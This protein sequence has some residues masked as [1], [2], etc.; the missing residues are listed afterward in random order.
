MKWSDAA[1]ATR[2]RWWPACHAGHGRPSIWPCRPWL[3]MSPISPEVPDGGQHENKQ[4]LLRIH[5]GNQKVEGMLGRKWFLVVF[6]RLFCASQ[7]KDP[8]WGADFA[9]LCQRVRLTVLKKRWLQ[10]DTHW[11]SEFRV[12]H[13]WW[14]SGI[15]TRFHVAGWNQFWP[16]ILWGTLRGLAWPII[17][18]W[19]RRRQPLLGTLLNML[20]TMLDGAVSHLNATEQAASET[21]QMK[22]RLADY[23]SSYRSMRVP[24]GTWTVW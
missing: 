18:A 17:G 11:S 22:S 15:F 7:V 5:F 23:I 4:S 2:F 8:L 10:V 13:R 20:G 3:S 19:K 1:C 6:A 9:W 12:K 16:A 21:S 14:S 24:T